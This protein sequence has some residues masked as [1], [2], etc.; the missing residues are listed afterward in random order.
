MAERNSVSR[1]LAVL[2]RTMAWLSTA[3]FVIVPAVLIYIF[4]EPD[5]SQWLMFDVDHLGAS[6]YATIPVQYRMLALACAMIP[7][8]FNMWALWSLRRLFLLYADGEVF[9][10]GA[11]GALNHVAIALFGGVIAS[12]VAQGPMSLALSWANGPHHREISLGFGSGDVSTLFMAGVVLV[13][14]RVMGEARRVADE[15]AAFV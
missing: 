8:A 7:A 4:L 15:N 9:S 14:A 13:V 3:G 1:N 12:F 6:L 5:R 10:S 11:L 2:S